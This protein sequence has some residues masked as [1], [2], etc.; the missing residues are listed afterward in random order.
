M[1]WS[2]RSSFW[3]TNH[4]ANHVTWF[5]FF[6]DFPI[7]S[8]L[9]GLLPAFPPLSNVLLDGHLEGR[10]RGNSQHRDLDN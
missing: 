1:L 8:N 10:T 9:R 2:L 6:F 3:S 7:T 5:A 4:P